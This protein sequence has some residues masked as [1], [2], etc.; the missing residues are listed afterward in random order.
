MILMRIDILVKQSKPVAA[1]LSIAINWSISK[2][3]TVNCRTLWTLA[4]DQLCVGYLLFTRAVCPLLAAELQVY[5]L[6][7][8]VNMFFIDR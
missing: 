6:H 2:T 8:L 5:L 1:N 4:A 3:F 7:F